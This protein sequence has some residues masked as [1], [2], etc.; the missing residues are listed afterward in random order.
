MSRSTSHPSTSEEA[1]EIKSVDDLQRLVADLE[2]VA[3]SE[4]ERAARLAEE[5]SDLKE[6]VAA[7]AALVETYSQQATQVEERRAL[8]TEAAALAAVTC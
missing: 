5:A 6:R 4:E 3:T 2:A 1:D 7:A 8:E